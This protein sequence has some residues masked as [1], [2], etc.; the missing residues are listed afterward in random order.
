MSG[1]RRLGPALAP[2]APAVVLLWLPR[3]VATLGGLPGAD[4]LGHTALSI[5]AL[6]AGGLAPLWVAAGWAKLRGRTVPGMIRLLRERGWL[7]ER[8]LR[9]L[10]L[11]PT[12]TAFFGTFALWKSSIPL[13]Y[14][15][16]VW[17]ARLERAE[18]WLHGGYPDRLLAPLVGSP[19]AIHVLDR[20]YHSWFYVL[21]AVVIW[22][23]W[24]SDHRKLRQFWTSFALLWTALGI[25][26]ATVFASAG[27]IYTGVDRGS[28][29][30]D[31]LIARLQA[32]EALGP[33]YVHLSAWS[34]WNA[35]RQAGVS[36][37]D[38]I[39]A[40]PSLHVAFV[41]LAALAASSA[42]RILGLVFWCYV[43]LIGIG[44]IMLGWHY[45]IDG[46]AA[47]LTTVL[48]WVSVGRWS[49]RRSPAPG[50]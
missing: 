13:F 49:N 9:F 1:W 18:L 5:P 6:M 14:P 46:E 30:Y 8:L 19:L 43:L 48:L 27:P 28:H 29:S 38:G 33:L 41:T 39:S 22:Q 7:G 20:V 4:G 44:S 26:A 15:G 36:L 35:A 47:V 32:A 34:L 42:N 24:G 23:A 10:V 21:F 12:V 2:I 25:V 3:L 45:A 11:A 50:P 16:F 40:F 17:D 37:G 31:G